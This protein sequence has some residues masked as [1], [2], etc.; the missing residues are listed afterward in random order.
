[1]DDDVK[2]TF[3]VF[4]KMRGEDPGPQEW[5]LDRRKMTRRKTPPSRTR[6]KMGS[7]RHQIHLKTGRPDAVW[8]RILYVL[9][10]SQI[11][12]KPC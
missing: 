10:C 7:V 4:R 3:E 2:K 11:S 9:F 5:A 1:M 12:A 6:S 8:V